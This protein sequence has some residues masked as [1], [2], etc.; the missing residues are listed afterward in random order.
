MIETKCFRDAFRDQLHEFSRQPNN[1]VKSIFNH[2]VDLILSLVI[3][4]K[5]WLYC[6]YKIFVYLACDPSAEHIVFFFW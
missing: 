5:H 1:M 2:F 3:K 6:I 4:L